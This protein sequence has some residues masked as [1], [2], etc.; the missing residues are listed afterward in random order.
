MAVSYNLPRNVM[1]WKKKIPKYI[2]SRYYKTIV[3]KYQT[4]INNTLRSVFMKPAVMLFHTNWEITFQLPACCTANETA[5]LWSAYFRNNY[6]YVVG[7]YI[8][9]LIWYEVLKLLA[10]NSIIAQH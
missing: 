8:L 6:Q 5:L 4:D 7:I 3:T 10:V 2:V 9:R 1:L